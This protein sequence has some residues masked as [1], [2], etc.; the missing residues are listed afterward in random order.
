MER[1]QERASPSEVTWQIPSRDNSAQVHRRHLSPWFFTN[2][3][4]QMPSSTGKV[5]R[6]KETEARVERTLQ[7][8][9]TTKDGLGGWSLKAAGLGVLLMLIGHVPIPGRLEGRV[10]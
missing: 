3:Y 6:Y 10:G 9:L 2:A 8:S 4:R 5:Q 1:T 7:K